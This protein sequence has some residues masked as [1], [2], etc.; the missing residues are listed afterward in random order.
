MQQYE[1]RGLRYR[2]WQVYDITHNRLVSK[3]LYKHQAE[4]LFNQLSRIALA[5]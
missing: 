1:I 3:C 5:C 4:E 2:E